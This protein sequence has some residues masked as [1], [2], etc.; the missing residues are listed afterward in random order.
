MTPDR[1][2]LF[3]VPA[4]VA[5]FN[6]AYMGPALKAV[7]ETGRA[8]L[9]ARA[10]PW[11]VTSVDFFTVADRVRAAAARL[12]DADADGVAMIPSVSY[13][14][15][16]AA[17]NIAL[18]AGDEIVTLADQFPSNI[19]IWRRRAEE[20]GARIVTVD[21]RQGETWTEAL[22]AALTSRTRI[23]AAPHVHWCDGGIVDLAAVGA[24]ARA[25]GAALVLDLTQ[26][27]GV[28]PFDA[29]AVAPDFVA[30]GHY[31]WLLGPY[32]TGFLYAAPHRRDGRPLEEG[33]IAREGAQD[34]ARLIDY[35]DGYDV[36]ARRYDVGERANFQLL[37]QAA[38]ALEALADFDP[39]A[40][41]AALG[42]L[43]AAL[44]PELTALGC[45]AEP[46]R[47][48][49]PHYLTVRLPSD[50]PSDLISRLAAE[51]VFVSQRGAHLRVTGHLHI[52]DADAERLLAALARALA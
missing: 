32:S 31:K 18:E 22:L 45:A 48:R 42:A 7:M 41:S 37:P 51:N 23:V 39:T 43:N 12:L 19:Y 5:Y 34:F 35:R 16:T 6:A 15:A 4:D 52:N 46:E 2:D 20:T 10:A 26:S 17:Q 11:K 44:L 27:L 1:R 13:G 24:A 40:T 47:V 49:S 33:W 3:D 28:L 36:G 38:V 50:A 30:A 21:R 25:R 29:A 9:S 8:A 14:L